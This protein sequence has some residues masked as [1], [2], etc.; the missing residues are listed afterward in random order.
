M[1]TTRGVVVCPT[2]RID[3]RNVSLTADVPAQDLRRYLLYWD[4]IAYAFPNGFGA[5]N[6]DALHDLNFLKQEGLL[7]LHD[8]SV[9]AEDIGAFNI[10]TP[11]RLSAASGALFSSQEPTPDN[12]SGLL[13]LDAPATLWRDLNYFAPHRAAVEL[14]RSDATVWSVAQTGSVFEFAARGQRNAPILETSLIGALPVPSEEVALDDILQFRAA[15]Q[16][17]ILRLRAAIDELRDKTLRAEDLSRGLAKSRDELTLAIHELHRALTAGKV[18]TFFSTM[19]MY[20]ALSFCQ[21]LL[22]AM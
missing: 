6:L 2:Y 10:A 12:P 17:E 16:S 5:P 9:T 22:M 14:E 21:M 18:R 13:I 15:R 20:M 4:R 8:T 11:P 1:A 3:G 19:K 7:T